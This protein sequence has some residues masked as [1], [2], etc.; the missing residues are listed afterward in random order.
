M[1]KILKWGGIIL[2]VLIVIGALSGGGDTSTKSDNSAPSAEVMEA[3]GT[4]E[5]KTT[6]DS[7]FTMGQKNAIRKA[8]SYLSIS[9]WSKSGLI[10]Q[11]EFE[12]FSTEDATFAVEN[13]DV[14]WNEQAAKKAKSY[15]DTSAFSRDGLI[16]QLEF[17]GFTTEQA[18][19]GVDAVGL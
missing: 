11:L 2:V 3:E 18:T 5:T 10:K 17:D 16:G 8:E 7:N 19:Y 4:N 9:G 1:K 12:K 14:D 13:I 6:E 15:L